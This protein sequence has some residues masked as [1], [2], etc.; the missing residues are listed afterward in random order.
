MSSLAAHFYEHYCNFP[1]L[2]EFDDEMMTFRS[3]II[4]F[5]SQDYLEILETAEFHVIYHYDQRW[6]ITQHGH[7][8]G[9]FEEEED[10]VS[11]GKDEELGQAHA[12]AVGHSHSYSRI[13]TWKE[14]ITSTNMYNF[15]Q[16]V[17]ISQASL[18]AHFNSLFN[19]AQAVKATDYTAALSKWNYDQYFSATF[20]PITL[21]LLS[22]GKAIIWFHLEEGYLKTLRN[23]LPWS[24]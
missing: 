1:G 20:K 11:W 16:I 22:N 7:F 9:E 6:S 2:D 15:D 8:G 19:H 24:E 10:E 3:Y 13:T 18:N 4:D 14:V 12:G 17:A 5:F 23:W 21:R